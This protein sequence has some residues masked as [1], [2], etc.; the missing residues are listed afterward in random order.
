MQAMNLR[1]VVTGLWIVACKPEEGA[2]A[3][4]DAATT[5]SAT[6]VATTEAT[7]TTTS[8]AGFECVDGGIGLAFVWSGTAP[9][10]GAAEC[11]L[12]NDDTLALDCTGDF[13]GIFTLK[14]ADAMKPGVVAGDVLAVDYRVADGDAALGEWLQVRGQNQWW[15]VAGQGP[16]VAP[17]DAPPDWFHPNVEVTP[18]AGECT[19]I[20]CNDA[21]GQTTPRA[22]AFGQGDNVRVLAAGGSGGVPGEF[23]GESYTAVVTEARTGTCGPAAQ[24]DRELVAFY[25]ISS[26]FQ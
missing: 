22:V 23:G 24:A 2:S 9:D 14:L 16:T 26:G 5:T 21:T 19:P 12:I 18:V 17:P 8:D 4:D 7:P 1:I 25:V 6:D 15:I 11:T 3:T 13:T 10:P 20:A